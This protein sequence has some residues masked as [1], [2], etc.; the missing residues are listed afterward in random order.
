MQINVQLRHDNMKKPNK[1]KSKTI[2]KF[3]SVERLT[4]QANYNYRQR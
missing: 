2:P 3:N 1:P 4:S